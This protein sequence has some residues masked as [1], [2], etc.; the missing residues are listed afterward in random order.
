MAPQTNNNNRPN[1]QGRPPMGGGRPGMGGSNRGQG[2][3]RE[4]RN[5]NSMPEGL[6][7]KIVSIRRVARVYKGGKRMRLSVMVVVGDKQGKIG[8]GIGK[9]ADV[10]TAEEKATKKAQKEMIQINKKANTIA[11]AVTHKRGAAK[12]ILKPAAPGTGIIAGGAVRA[13]VEL[14]GIKDILS[15]VLGTNNKISNVYAT[16]EALTK[17]KAGK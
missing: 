1:M 6:D 8:V 11:H 17:L 15:K 4:R 7:K 16:I 2:Q 3:R 13:V 5:N 12:V 10:R 14:A 9:G